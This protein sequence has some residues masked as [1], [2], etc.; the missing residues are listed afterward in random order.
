MAFDPDKY[1]QGNGGGFDPD[2]YLAGS[3]EQKPVNFDAIEKPT[4]F[5]DLM[6]RFGDTAI[7]KQLS[8]AFGGNMRGS[9]VGRLMQGMADPG[10]ALAQLTANATGSN[11]DAVNKRIA[12]VEQQYQAAR[13]QAGSTGFDPL[14]MA[15][16]IAMT[17]PLAGGTAPASLLGRAGQGA[18]HGAGFS[19]L[20]PVTSGDFEEEKA[21][22]LL[23]GAAV[24]GVAAPV[25]GALARLVSPKASLDPGVKALEHAGIKLTPGQALGGVANR[26]EEKAQSLPILGD[27]ITAARNRGTEQL[28][29]AVLDRAVAGIGGKV[30][31]VGAE[32]L[33]QARQQLG[34]AYDDLLPKMSVQATDPAFINKLSSLR[35]MVQS[36]PER[37]ARQFDNIIAREIDARLA[38]NGVL[39][40]QN[41]KEAQSA[42]SQKA[43]QFAKS[44]DA[45]Q[46]DLGQAL[47]QLDAE[48][49]NW[50]RQSNPQ[51]AEQLSAI[52]KGYA[53][54][55]RAQRAGASLG[56]EAGTFTPAQLQ[57]AV[58]AMDRSKDKRAF[59]EG[60]AFLQDLS[61]P[62]KNL[63]TGKT[64][65]SGTAGR[66]LLGAGGVAA[67]AVNPAIPAALVGGAAMYAP[68]IQNFLV[69][70]MTK[71]PEMA[72]R[73]AEMLRNTTPYLAAASAP[74]VAQAER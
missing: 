7:G 51:F 13:E 68:P 45:Y 3:G 27:A 72:Q 66:L 24:G 64:P 39:Y 49:R 4:A 41:L 23:A 10:A 67:G 30:D 9:A 33:A 21:K 54:F 25:V 63:M 32:G 34:Q 36:L 71:R 20:Q 70:L 17:A 28:N 38:P 50:V 46:S 57:N 37:E 53:V 48:L 29:K 73:I 59:S 26:M 74:A 43:S 42:I 47:K 18:M 69:A 61:G 52:D 12:D 14:R 1:L 31:K 58:K 62:A 2:A 6:L 5:D 56:S 40:G 11:A 22:Q 60:T 8:S 35:S 15:G 19:V 16:N 44:N 65:D 55:K